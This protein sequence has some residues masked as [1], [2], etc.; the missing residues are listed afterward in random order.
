[1]YKDAYWNDYF[2][3][4]S[5][6]LG[7]F[8]AVRS[9]DDTLQKTDRHQ[10]SR[11]FGKIKRRCLIVHAPKM[12]N[13]FSDRQLEKRLKHTYLKDHDVSVFEKTARLRFRKND[14]LQLNVLIKA[15]D[16]LNQ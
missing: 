10:P 9:V 5:R 6:S 14:N 8:V 7:R 12:F 16:R 4:I 1:L 11:V 15:L 3:Y 2:I 13:K